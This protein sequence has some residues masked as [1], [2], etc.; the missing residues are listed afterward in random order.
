VPNP[1]NLFCQDP[2]NGQ[3]SRRP[4]PLRQLTLNVD[5]SDYAAPA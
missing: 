1:G 3:M 4:N 5:S 2:V